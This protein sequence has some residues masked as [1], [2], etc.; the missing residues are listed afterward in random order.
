MLYDLQRLNVFVLDTY[1]FLSLYS[2]RFQ[3]N[4]WTNERTNERT[5]KMKAVEKKEDDISVYF[6]LFKQTT[7][8]ISGDKVNNR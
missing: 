2:N 6:Y 7:N 8:V 4:K 1:F 3:M 5:F